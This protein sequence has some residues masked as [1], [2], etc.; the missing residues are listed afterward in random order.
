[1]DTWTQRLTLAQQ[2]WHTEARLTRSGVGSSDPHVRSFRMWAKRMHWFGWISDITLHEG[3]IVSIEDPEQALQE[4][5]HAATRVFDVCQLARREFSHTIPV[6][7]HPISPDAPIGLVESE[8]AMQ[9]VGE[10]DDKFIPSEDLPDDVSHYAALTDQTL[11]QGM[12]LA[13]KAGFYMED[14]IDTYF[15]HARYASDCKDRAWGW[16]TRLA[17]DDANKTDMAFQPR[18]ITSD[19]LDEQLCTSLL[20]AASRSMVSMRQR[21]TSGRSQNCTKNGFPSGFLTMDEF[22]QNNRARKR[23]V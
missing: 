15:G 23:R 3:C 9:H 7:K 10:K 13:S 11:L 12:I 21:Y 22:S 6:L 4:M 2:G 5:T 20:S 1:M 18:E 19:D 16:R 14:R 17:Y 8:W